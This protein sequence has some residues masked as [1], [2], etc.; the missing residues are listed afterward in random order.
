M[1]PSGARSARDQALS[2][3]LSDYRGHCTSLKISFIRSVRLTIAL[4]DTMEHPFGDEAIEDRRREPVDAEDHDSGRHAH[5]PTSMVD[6]PRRKA[7]E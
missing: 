3:Y 6:P 4:V 2:D 7:A 1:G 5:H